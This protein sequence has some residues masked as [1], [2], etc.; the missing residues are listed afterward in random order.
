VPTEYRVRVYADAATYTYI[1]SKFQTFW[2]NPNI[3]LYICICKTVYSIFI[4]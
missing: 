3:S 4:I 2:A 1:C